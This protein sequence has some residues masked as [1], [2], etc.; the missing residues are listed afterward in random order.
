MRTKV[1]EAV[2]PQTA[3]DGAPDNEERCPECDAETTVQDGRRGETVCT[4]CGLVL[5]ESAIDPGPEWRAFD[6]QQRNKRARTGPSRTVMRHDMGLGSQ[7]GFDDQDASPQMR[8]QLGRL[9]RYH[10]RATYKPGADRNVARGL[11]EIQRLRAA[12]GLPDTVGQTAAQIYRQ[13]QSKDFLHGRSVEGTA[14]AAVYAAARIQGTPRR[15]EEVID[16]A[17]G[18][19]ERIRR[20]YRRLNQE[21]ELPVPVLRP[22]ELIAMIGSKLE[23]PQTVRETARDL[24]ARTPETRMAGKNPTSVAAAALYRAAQLDDEP[25]TQA[26]TAEAADVT[27]VTLRNRLKDLPE[28]AA[29]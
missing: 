29:A 12:L 1:H 18:D 22:E 28:Q 14:A 3:P 21:L 15:L 2:D 9:R 16:V 5:S 24:I 8:R 7:I 10:Q 25:R 17:A 23:L 20:T 6:A 13:A 11:S 26:E 4:Q 19:P 27:T